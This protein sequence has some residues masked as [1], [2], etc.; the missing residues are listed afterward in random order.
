MQLPLAPREDYL[1]MKQQISRNLV[2]VASGLKYKMPPISSYCQRR[3]L[4]ISPAYTNESF[5]LELLGAWEPTCSRCP[6]SSCEGKISQGLI[7]DGN[8]TISRGDAAGPGWFTLPLH[9]SYTKWTKKRWL[10]FTVEGGCEITYTNLLTKSYRCTHPEWIRPTME[11]NRFLRM[12]GG[13]KEEGVLATLKTHAHKVFS[14]MIM[15][16]RF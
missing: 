6:L 12:A 13:T 16:W 1:R 4:R 8:K 7:F 14:P 3:R 10:G 5:K 15:L 11:V 9:V 2:R